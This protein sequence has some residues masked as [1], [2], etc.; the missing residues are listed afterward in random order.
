MIKNYE[1]LLETFIKI[2][3]TH[4]TDFSEIGLEKYR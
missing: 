4:N 2:H 3:N 1:K